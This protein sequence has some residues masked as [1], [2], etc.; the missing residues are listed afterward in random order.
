MAPVDYPEEIDG[1]FQVNRFNRVDGMGKRGGFL[2]QVPISELRSA[3]SLPADYANETAPA[4]LRRPFGFEFGARQ[5]VR[6]VNIFMPPAPNAAGSMPPAPNA[7][8]SRLIEW[9]I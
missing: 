7:A 8:G 1:R 5:H 6:P 9:L 4:L 2:D 3:P